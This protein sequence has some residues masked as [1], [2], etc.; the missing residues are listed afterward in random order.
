MLY[1][2]CRS[3]FLSGTAFKLCYDSR[4]SSNSECSVK[5]VVSSTYVFEAEDNHLKRGLWGH[6]VFAARYWPFFR[7]WV[8]RS[9]ITR[10]S[11]TSVGLL[12]AIFQPLLSSLVYLFVFSLVM[13]VSTGP[14][15][16]G[17]FIITSM[18]LWTYFNRIVFSGA[19]S[20]ITNLDIITRVRFPREFLPLAVVAESLVD[21]FFGLIIV[22]MIFLITGQPITPYMLLAVW[23][24]LALTA[25]AL[26]LGFIFAAL[27]SSV[28]D[29]LQVLPIL[30][31]LSL[32]LTP[33]IY[34]ITAV[35]PTI[36]SLF[37]INPLAPIFTAWQETMLYGQFTVAGPMVISSI[38][39]LIVLV[40]GYLFFKRSEWLFADRL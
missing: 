13:R 21:L 15:P 12:W 32:Y 28:R 38:V 22:A 2:E 5:N 25:F 14:V 35:P 16:Y 40:L 1:A 11:A 8:R 9:I 34:P 30:I 20:I 39:S 31:Q 17:L 24:F 23:P 27:T 33:V 36:Q 6:L 37:I 29:L 19:S 18:V 26:G 10:Y 7:Y 3:I 4:G